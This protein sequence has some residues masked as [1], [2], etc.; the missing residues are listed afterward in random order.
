MKIRV[1]N[2]KNLNDFGKATEFFSWKLKCISNLRELQCDKTY[3]EM[4]RQCCQIPHPSP[5]AHAL[6]SI[7]S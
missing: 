5:P 3:E 2:L 1:I 7:N 4:S 6:L